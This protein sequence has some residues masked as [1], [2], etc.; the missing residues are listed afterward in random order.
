MDPETIKTI[1][2]IKAA[3]PPGSLGSDEFVTLTLSEIDFKRNE[4]TLDQGV[5]VLNQELDDKGVFDVS[6]IFMSNPETDVDARRYGHYCVSFDVHPGICNLLNSNSNKITFSFKDGV[7]NINN[8]EI[9]FGSPERK[10]NGYFVLESLFK[11][12]DKNYSIYYWEI[13]DENP[14]DIYKKDWMVLYRACAS[15]QA[16]VGKKTGIGDLLLYEA[17]PDGSVK[18]NP[19][20]LLP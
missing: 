9:T 1:Q 5:F 20:Y 14:I 8:K 6:S 13:Q 11:R 12:K 3:L 16:Q 4:M 2:I 7:L 19:K 15:I 18:I 17:S 10:Q